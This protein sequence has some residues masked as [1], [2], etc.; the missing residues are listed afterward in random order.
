MGEAV[1]KSKPKTFFLKEKI[2]CSF[3]S[4]NALW[5]M[6]FQ[7]LNL[8]RNISSEVESSGIPLKVFGQKCF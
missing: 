3:S 2:R 7:H 8:E 4:N 5:K 1:W 6:S